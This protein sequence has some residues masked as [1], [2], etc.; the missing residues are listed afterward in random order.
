M[1]TFAA[2]RS[3]VAGTLVLAAG[4]GSNMMG[5]EAT[6]Q[7]MSVSPRGGTTSVAVATEIVLTFSQAMMGGMERFM[8]LHQG[9]ASG[10]TIPMSCSWSEGQ[11]ALTCRP[12]QPLAAGTRYTV[13][14]GSGMM[15]S[16]GQRVGM[17]R[18]RMGMGGSPAG[19]MGAGASCGNGSD[20]MVF[21]FTT[22]P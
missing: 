10:P 22:G 15:D 6:T 8:I 14:L 7:L 12:G 11:T 9:S 21:D 20:G 4:C 19:M 2:V 18:G 16:R 17:D 13:H 3:V 5:T 1:F